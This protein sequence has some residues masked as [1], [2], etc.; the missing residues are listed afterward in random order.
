V[1]PGA[2]I[3]LKMTL[4]VS[5]FGHSV[6]RKDGQP[7]KKDEVIFLQFSVTIEYTHAD[8]K[9]NDID[10]FVD[11]MESHIGKDYFRS[12]DYQ[13]ATDLKDP[14]EHTT[15]YSIFGTDTVR[16]VAEE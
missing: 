6:M 3:E 12:E 5:V 11:V 1:R 15:W 13:C 2:P 10:S 4:P 14:A 9:G 8:D 7:L 16:K